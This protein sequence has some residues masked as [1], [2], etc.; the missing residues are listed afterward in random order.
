[1]STG[2]VNF[3]MLKRETSFGVRAAGPSPLRLLPADSPRKGVL[4]QREL[5][6]H[7]AFRCEVCGGTVDTHNAGPFSFLGDMR[8]RW[9]GVPCLE[10]GASYTVELSDNPEDA[11]MDVS[12]RRMR[13]LKEETIRGAEGVIDRQYPPIL[14]E[15]GPMGRPI[16]D[17]GEIRCDCNSPDAGACRN[18]N[19]EDDACR[20]V[21]HD[22]A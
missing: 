9:V 19:G 10:C 11:C 22:F 18:G 15:D 3:V 8:V 20:C 1:M 13:R 7:A 16:Y 6:A 4:G 5:V 12:E 2:A 21:C 14:E 17:T